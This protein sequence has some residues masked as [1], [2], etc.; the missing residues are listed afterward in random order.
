MM[1]G[2]LL[3]VGA[4]GRAAAA[5]A[6]RAGFDPFVID[7]FAD[8]DTQRLCPVLKCDPSDYPHGFIPLAENA[9]AGPWMYTGGLENHPEVV[10][11]ISKYRVLLGNDYEVLQTARNERL[12]AERVR[13]AGGNFP[14][15]AEPGSIPSDDRIWIRKP[16]NSSGGRGIRIAEKHDFENTTTAM[17]EM[18]Q[19]FIHGDPMSAIYFTRKPDQ[20]RLFGIT[21]QLVGTTWLHAKNFEYT[22]NISTMDE[23]IERSMQISPLAFNGMGFEF[24]WGED[25]IRTSKGPFTIEINPRYTAAI[26][27]LEHATGTAIMAEDW[28]ERTCHRCVI[29]KGIY[30]APHSFTFPESGAWDD[31]LANCTDDW[32]LHHYADIPH[33]GSKIEVGQPVIT[34]FAEGETETDCLQLLQRRAAELDRLFGWETSP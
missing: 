17:R 2:P 19:V 27:V 22:G 12:I 13:H 5:S 20:H 6:I 29:A 31:S 33:A 30:Y 11:A 8:A 32:T 23:K 18:L 14:A 21:R 34:I 25:F 26:E 1:R 7:L 15:T 10:E 9:P 16:R 24:V 28:L 3:I 4:S